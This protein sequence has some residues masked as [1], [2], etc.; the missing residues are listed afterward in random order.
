VDVGGEYKIPF[1][2]QA[3]ERDKQ[4]LYKTDFIKPGLEGLETVYMGIR[5]MKICQNKLLSYLQQIIF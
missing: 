3:L 1:S 5:K 4:P 2:R